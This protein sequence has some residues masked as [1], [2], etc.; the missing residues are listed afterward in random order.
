MSNASFRF[1]QF[2]LFQNRCAMK[3]G[4]DGVL[5]GAWTDISE[6]KNL[7][8]IGTGTGLLA[9]MFAQRSSQILVTAVEIDKEA[10][11][12]AEEN[13]NQS[14]W[15][16]RIEVLNEDILTYCSNTKFDAIVSNPPYFNNNLHPFDKQR[17]LARHNDHFTYPALID[18]VVQF[19]AFDGRFSVILPFEQKEEFITLCNIRGLYLKR[20]VNVQTIPNAPYKRVLMEFSLRENNEIYKNTLLIEEKRHCYSTE[21]IELTKDFYLKM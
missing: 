12:Q 7:L 21:Y 13:V 10:A 19:L 14:P 18:K 8:D 2:T 5:L 3:V 20:K 9:L 6:A 11:E 16:D 1:K 17:I 15:K 4:T